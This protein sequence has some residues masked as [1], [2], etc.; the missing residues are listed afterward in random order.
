MLKIYL[1]VASSLEGAPKR[2]EAGVRGSEPDR[3]PDLL[4]GEARPLREGEELMQALSTSMGIRSV[5]YH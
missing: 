5:E 4:Q 3:C 1:L 2:P